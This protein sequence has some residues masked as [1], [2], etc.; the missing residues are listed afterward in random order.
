MLNMMARTEINDARTNIVLAEANLARGKLTEAQD[1]I[2]NAERHYRNARSAVTVH[3]SD[4]ILNNLTDLRIKLDQMQ[5]L[6]TRKPAT[7]TA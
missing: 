6:V 4:S 2:A 1:A 3:Q 7:V 5:I